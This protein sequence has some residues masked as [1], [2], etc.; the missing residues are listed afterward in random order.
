MRNAP[1][2]EGSFFQRD[3][4]WHPPAYT[5]G[6]KTSVVRSPQKALISLD[7]TI[8][9]MTGSTLHTVSRLLAAWEKSRIVES[10]HRHISV[11]DPARLEALSRAGGGAAA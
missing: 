1:K 3:R 9:E 4:A 11:R 7:N 10:R 5:P 6:Y 2:S 8:S